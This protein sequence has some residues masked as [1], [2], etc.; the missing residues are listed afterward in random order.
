M[1][2]AQAHGDE[3]ESQR[4]ED[5]V[6]GAERPGRKREARPH[7]RPESGEHARCDRAPRDDSAGAPRSEREHTLR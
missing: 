7:D 5:E 3:R 6:E 2:D 1:G 4:D